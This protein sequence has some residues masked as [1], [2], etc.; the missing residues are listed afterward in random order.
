MDLPKVSTEIPIKVRGDVMGPL[1]DFNSST[2]DS[3]HRYIPGM[4]SELHQLSR[5]AACEEE[6][7]APAPP[8]KNLVLPSLIGARRRGSIFDFVEPDRIQ[9]HQQ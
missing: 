8:A 4:M 5:L 9:F 6:S 7:A 2:S 3:Y 1:F